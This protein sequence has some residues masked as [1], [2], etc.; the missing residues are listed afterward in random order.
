MEIHVYHVGRVLKKRRLN[1]VVPED[2]SKRTQEITTKNF[3]INLDVNKYDCLFVGRDG[4]GQIIAV[5]FA[6]VYQTHITLSALSTTKQGTGI[7][8]RFLPLV[9]LAAA[10][11]FPWITGFK[12]TAC[13]EVNKT[14]PVV[15]LRITVTTDDHVAI[16]I[17]A[18][19]MVRFEQRLRFYV[20]LGYT[21]EEETA[22]YARFYKS[23]RQ[24]N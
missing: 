1:D 11:T 22:G 8:S 23:T 13:D 20:R 10:K 7:G 18:T 19:A 3:D 21:L 17:R 9:E 4:S 14:D 6:Y 5:V 24:Q 16:I 2:V 12:L 15:S